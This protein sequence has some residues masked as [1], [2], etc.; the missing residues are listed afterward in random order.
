M[1]GGGFFVR[2]G[3]PRALVDQLDR[4]LTKVFQMPDVRSALID[5]GSTP[6]G[7]TPEQFAEIIR[8]EHS[9]YG[10]LISEAGINLE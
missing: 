8:A 2:S 3:T 9:R 10:K 7:N 1:I 5:T 4:A 6:I